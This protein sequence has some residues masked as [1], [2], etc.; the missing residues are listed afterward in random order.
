MSSIG[1][2]VGVVALNLSI[3]NPYFL[4]DFIHRFAACTDFSSDSI[5]ITKDFIFNP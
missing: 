5:V 2:S 4:P 3:S 1:L